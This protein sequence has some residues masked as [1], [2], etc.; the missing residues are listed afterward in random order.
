MARDLAHINNSGIHAGIQQN[1]SRKTLRH[2]HNKH[3]AAVF[4]LVEGRGKR[5]DFRK[6]YRTKATRKQQLLYI[7][8]IVSDIKNCFIKPFKQA[9]ILADKARDAASRLSLRL[10]Q[11]NHE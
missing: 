7:S 11:K 1:S 6:V 2:G 4:G 10:P 9:I 8:Q 3:P 5:I